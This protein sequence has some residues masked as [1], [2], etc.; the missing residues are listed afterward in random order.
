M[1]RLDKLNANTFIFN[2]IITDGAS[3]TSEEMLNLIENFSPYPLE[4]LFV[5]EAI[6]FLSLIF[7]HSDNIKKQTA[8]YLIAIRLLKS[9]FTEKKDIL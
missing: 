6:L 4:D 7:I 9:I 8:F 5:I 2:L 3:K 1:Y